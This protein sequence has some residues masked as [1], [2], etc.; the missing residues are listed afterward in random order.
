M[1][2]LEGIFFA[3]GVGHEGGFD[4][5]LLGLVDFFLG[6]LGSAGGDGEFVG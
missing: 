3:L 2:D 6:E 5:I 4:G 1:D